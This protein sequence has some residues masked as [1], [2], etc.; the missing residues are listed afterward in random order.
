MSLTT[1]FTIWHYA[2]LIASFI[3]FL[4]LI[5]VSLQQKKRNIILPMIFSSFLVMALVT[6]FMLSALDKYT[7]KVEL[8]G[9][10]NRRLL[11]S[12][13]IVYSGYV[14]NVGDYTVGKVTVEFKL[15]NQGH[16]AGN[17]K[18]GASYFKPSGLVEFFGGGDRK[19]YK[20]QKIVENVV[21]ARNLEPGKTKYFSVTMDFP[22]YFKN[23]MHF[24]R[25]FAH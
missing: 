18:E 3:V 25:I 16:L 7:K 10:D 11:M 14:T 13:K 4:L 6:I 22:P 21:V 17:F 8:T 20:P 1:H 2:V 15:V 19:G 24:Q 9:L 5:I 12:E 23:V